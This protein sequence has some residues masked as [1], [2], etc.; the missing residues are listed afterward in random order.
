MPTPSK[1]DQAAEG[2][3]RE[4]AG[5]TPGE[6]AHALDV[7][8]ADTGGD[9]AQP[10]AREAAPGEPQRQA[11]P[12]KA[13]FD[14]RRDAI[15]ARFR[16]DRTTAAS[17]E[18]EDISEF[19]R[20]G[21]PPEFAVPNAPVINEQ[22]PEPAAAADDQ[23]Q[24]EPAAPPQ[25]VKIKVRGQ[26]QE[27]LM[28]DLIA[29][30]QIA[31]AADN[32]LD[33]AKGK[34]GEVDALL[35]QTRQQA[36]RAGQD[37]THPAAPQSAQPAEPSQGQ[38]E[39]PQHPEDSL[40]GLI[41]AIQF[42]N[43]EDAQALL[44]TTIASEAS[45]AVATTLQQQRFKDEGARTAKV[46]KDFETAHP[47]L[48]SDPMAR[49]AIEAN[50]LAQQTKD[51]AALGIDPATM[52]PDGLPPTP[53]DIANAHRYYRTEGFNVTA[54]DK[55][56]EQAADALLE[57]RGVK[58]PATPNQPAAPAQAQ[59]HVDVTIDRTARRAAIPQ[60]PARSA[61]PRPAQQQAPAPRDR[62]TI[63]QDM[64]AKRAQPRGRVLA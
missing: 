45:K 5:V 59:P 6:A 20:S 21:M 62:S 56:L 35:R 51:I 40:D 27:V 11:P 63:V 47:D 22:Q 19:A 18:A 16:D 37:G 48:A 13:P 10:Q 4:A 46:V 9:I 32:Y 15:V 33:E 38:P 44:K 36:P 31:Y 1:A 41:E 17:E 39:T 55:M 61:A 3:A 29:K 50:I 42:G 60:Q 34:L 57:W 2:A 7:L 25:K 54:P 30:A 43:P 24:P 64:I 12:V 58:K 26:E 53:G 8:D 23:G 14:A 49:A 28:D 52:R